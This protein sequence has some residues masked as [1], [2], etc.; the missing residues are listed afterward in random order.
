MKS[1]WKVTSNI[2]N[3]EKM[4]AVYRILDTSELDHSGNRE[5]YGEFTPDREAA[6]RLAAKLNREDKKKLCPRCGE[7]KEEFAVTWGWAQCFDCSV[8]L[9]KKEGE[10]RGKE[11]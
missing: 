11:C 1:E 7:A 2:I 9:R 5:H 3:G 8:E 10:G 4:Y 6:V